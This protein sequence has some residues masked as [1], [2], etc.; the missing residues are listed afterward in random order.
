MASGRSAKVHRKNHSGD[1][2]VFSPWKAQTH[3]NV[4]KVVKNDAICSMT[5]QSKQIIPDEAF[6]ME[7]KNVDA[8]ARLVF[9]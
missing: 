7:L 6:I 4:E 9:F 8:A 3:R 1:K 2:I 5:K